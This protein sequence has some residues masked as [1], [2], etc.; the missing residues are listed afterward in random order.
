M[1]AAYNGDKVAVDHLLDAGASLEITSLHDETALLLAIA[2]GHTEI[3]KALLEAGCRAEPS[4]VLQAAGQS[5]QSEQPPTVLGGR[6]TQVGWT[7]VMLACQTGNLAILGRLLDMG[8]STL[9][10]SP[11]GKT[12]L[13][14]A[15]ENGFTDIA[16][17]LS[18]DR[19]P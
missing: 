10:T 5:E 18:R 6:A 13:E 16:V 7:P 4:W 14:I 15:N 9:P 1:H 2:G 19:N 12:A 8:A 11:M 3:A 17:S